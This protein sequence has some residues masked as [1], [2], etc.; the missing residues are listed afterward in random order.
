MIL[1]PWL[2]I[3]AHPKYDYTQ[4]ICFLFCI[5]PNMFIY[6]YHVFHT[7]IRQ[8]RHQHN[9]ISYQYVISWPFKHIQVISPKPARNCP[10]QPL[11]TSFHGM[12]AQQCQPTQGTLGLGGENVVKP[13]CSHESRWIWSDMFMGE[14]RYSLGGIPL[15]R[16]VPGYEIFYLLGHSVTKRE[17]RE[18]R[19][20]IPEIPNITGVC[21]SRMNESM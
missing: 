4:K 1:F 18:V 12:N 15:A 19:V 10:P 11:E 17:V 8:T 9:P 2:L 21:K 5:F 16:G 3:C 20:T 14:N 7:T 13:T 6:C